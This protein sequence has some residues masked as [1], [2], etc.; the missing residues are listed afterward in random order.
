MI[1]RS[2]QSIGTHW[3]IFIDTSEVSESLWK[4]LHALMRNF[5]AR[6]SRFLPNSEVVQWREAQAGVYALSPE[7]FHMLSM[8]QSWKNETGGL[9][10]PAVGGLLEEAGYDS[11]YRFVESERLQSWKVPDWKVS[12]GC[13]HLDGPVV[14]DLG[15]FAKGTLIDMVCNFL[16]DFDQRYFLV[17]GGGDIRCTTK[18][19]GD[20]WKTAVEW[21]G[22]P[23]FALCALTLRDC[24]L[25]VSDI[26]QRRWGQWHHVVNPLNTR[27]ASGFVGCAVTAKT[28]E[29]ADGMTTC[30]SLLPKH[31]RL[32][33]AQKHQVEY[34]LMTPH[35]QVEC[36]PEWS[37]TF[38][39]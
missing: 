39:S 9:F 21:P 16:N 17:D 36:S 32:S 12:G 29:L 18:C 33:F 4:E 25:A 38:F 14:F 27:P 7:L 35:D 37:G 3:Q 22:R 24:A 8:A 1:R 28:C 2:F 34:L 15:A 31:L 11:S 6:F 23:G 20:G 30:L 26:H 5:E 13:V 10:N 19:S